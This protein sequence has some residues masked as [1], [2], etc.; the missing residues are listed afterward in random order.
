M[1]CGREHQ[2]EDRAAHKP[3]CNKI[4]KAQTETVRKENEL[5]AEDDDIFK[6][7]T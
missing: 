7:G 3:L 5:R 2:A 1:Y 4:K 6:D